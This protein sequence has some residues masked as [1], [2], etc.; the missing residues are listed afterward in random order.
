MPHEAPSL[1]ELF[2]AALD[3]AT[4]E[5]P[6]WLERECGPD[7]ELRQRIELMLAAHD[8]PQS[9]L[10]RLAP[11]PEPPSAATGAFDVVAA[12]R[13]SP[14]AA[15]QAGTVVAGRYKLLEPIGEGGFGVV[16]MAEQQQPVRRKVALKVL[17][18]G[19]DTRQ[20][21]ARFEAER[22][23]LALMD[24]PNIAQVFDGGETDGGRPYFVMELVRGV[25]ITEFCDQKQLDVRAR[26][27]LFVSVCAAVQHA[28]QKGVIH[29]D[30]KPSNV[31]V[32][33]HDGQPVVK[34]IDFGIAKAV[35]QQLTERTL[36]TNFA[37]MVGTPLYMSPE[38]A[39]LSGLDIDTRSDVYS[40]GVLL[41]ELLTGTTPFDRERLRHVG[42]DEMRRIIREEEPPKPST[43]ISTVGQAATTASSKRRSDPRKLGRLFRGELDWVVMKAL[44]KDRDRRYESASAFAADVQRYLADEAVLACPPGVGYRLG[45]LVRR[46]KGPVVAA[47][48]VALVLVAGIA[49]TSTGLV[50]ALDA[51]QQA[52]TDRD[53]KAAALGKVEAE[54]DAKDRALR[55]KAEALRAKEQALQQAIAATQAEAQARRQTRQALSTLTSEVVEELLGQQPVLTDEMRDFLKRVLVMHEAFAARKG[56]D[57][58][59]RESQAEGCLCVGLIRYQLG[60]LKDAEPAY[61]DALKLLE[62]LVAELPA[63]QDLRDSLARAYSNLGGVLR[64][65]GRYE[66]AESV[67]RAALARWKK[68]QAE[69]PAEAKYRHLVA[70]ACNN[71]GHALTDHG[72]L[73]EAEAV[74]RDGVAL[75][76]QLVREFP[77]RLDF[78]QGLGQSYLDLGIALLDTDRPDEAEPVLAKAVDLHESL[79]KRLPGRADLRRDLAAS[80]NSLGNALRE[81]ESPKAEAAFR[82]ALD[83]YQ[84]LVEEFPGLPTYAQELAGCHFSL[85][86]QFYETQRP[87]DAEPSF[88][89]ALAMGEKLAKR[90]PDR[91]ELRWDVAQTHL[92]LAAMFTDTERWP[93]AEAALQAA[94][95][96]L[97]PLIQEFPNRPNYRRSQGRALHGLGRLLRLTVRTEEAVSAYRKALAVR[98]QLARDFPW[99][100]EFRSELAASQFSL[101]A[102]LA[103]RGNVPEAESLYRQAV[104]IGEKLTQEFPKRPG[105][106][107]GLA[108]CYHN[109]GNMLRRAKRLQEAEAAHRA[110][111][112]LLQELTAAHPML[113]RFRY[114]LAHGHVSLGLLLHDAQRNKEAEES[115]RTAL[116]LLQD[117]P[118]GY[119]TPAQFRETLARAHLNLGLVLARTNRPQEAVA[120]WRAALPLW[121]QLVADAPAAADFQNELAGTLMNLAVVHYQRGESAA[122]VALGEQARPHHQA[123]LKL[124]P[125][126][127]LYR[128]FY[129]NSLRVLGLSYG[130]V[131]NHARLSV[132]ADELARLD[133]DP[134]ADLYNAAFFLSRCMTLA[135]T[136]ARLS[137]AR[138]AELI[139]SYGFRAVVLLRQIVARG[140]KRAIALQQDA[141]FQPLQA[142]PLF[143]QLL[144]ELNGQTKE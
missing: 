110:A 11:A 113:H 125:A 43:R 4:A 49:G 76:E 138:R 64:A 101:A 30:I 82:R 129:Q 96:V 92:G 8:T 32:T 5:R 88:R 35:G 40:L 117:V 122:A 6:A 91:P 139:Q 38:Q 70:L 112:A 80:S 61:R 126:S 34:V 27:A 107:S 133:L 44:E 115:Y 130:D 90:F 97:E 10:D 143:R 12:E 25:P 102:L 100:P 59:G 123:A 37:Q 79:V 1:K 31:L 141:N 103:D 2:L 77:E 19:M 16:F 85:G 42:F 41:Y 21:V 15:E 116:A 66:E 131:G 142:R 111:Q 78:R 33:L 132:T 134:A 105:F 89:T 95:A 119:P 74:Q 86:V 121:Q 55:E 26:L 128:R 13:A 53:D 29:R 93:E 136:D 68:L 87:K 84:R 98:E 24:H 52:L 109:L 48:V 120:A 60:E 137:E 9:L 18:P 73:A 62:Q 83:L 104:A 72:R 75:C 45:K 56:T 54:R 67:H 28:H 23:A 7:T 58:E 63:R 3:V 114:E 36:F 124:N 20:V 14:M 65:K 135:E 50:R 57:T 69:F 22:Q 39:E 140:Y 51:E 144:A 99:R 17:K 106:R 127:P 81:L 47:A 71:L 94:L 118:A 46:H 108:M